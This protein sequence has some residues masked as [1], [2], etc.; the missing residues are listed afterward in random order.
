M[1]VTLSRLHAVRY[2]LAFDRMTRE[3]GV[4][5]SALVAFTGEV[6][7]GGAVYTE[8]NMNPGVLERLEWAFKDPRFRA[9]IVAEK[10]QTGFDEPMLHTM[11]VDKKLADVV[12]ETLSRLN[13]TAPA[14]NETFVLDFANDPED[15]LKEFQKHY[16]RAVL[17][18]GTDPNTLYDVEARLY[19]QGLFSKGEVD[20][21]AAVWSTEGDPGAGARA[22]RR[23]LRAVQEGPE[24]PAAGGAGGAHAVREPLRLP[25]AGAAVRGR[26]AR[27]AAR[28]RGGAA[29]AS[30]RSSVS[31]RPSRCSGWCS[32]TPTDCGGWGVQTLR[33][34]KQI[35]RLDPIG[36]Q[37]KIN[38]MPS[39]EEPRASCASSTSATGCR[40]MRRAPP[41]K[42]SSAGSF[43]T[44]G[45]GGA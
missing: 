42:G 38:S 33:L 12:A 18:V 34:R 20:A 40:R 11:Y 16:D 25:V 17:R 29:S 37:P 7:D 6:K 43:A 10:F 32:S 21:F 14:K 35:A 5:W 3:A 36:A 27:T 1:V 4:P 28:L 2:K 15:I 13:R 19:G 31:A 45:C 9:L 30:S 23:G 39:S 24:P 41:W 44:R 22:P 26:L 8:A